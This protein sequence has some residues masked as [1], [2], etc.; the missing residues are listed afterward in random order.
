MSA[1]FHKPPLVLIRKTG[2]MSGKLK[3]PPFGDTDMRKT[4]TY[5]WGALGGSMK[6]MF[7]HTKEKPSATNGVVKKK[8]KT[9]TKK[10]SCPLVT[11]KG[12]L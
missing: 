9:K 4:T 6:P 1:L 2:N 5:H 11:G 7:F 10:T 12:W 3:D 8:T